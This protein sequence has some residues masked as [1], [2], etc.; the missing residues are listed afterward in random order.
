M[1]AGEIAGLIAAVAFVLL[2]GALAVPL[3]K[4]GKVLDQ[5]GR[6]V[7]GVTDR[8]VPLL[9]EVT[10]TVTSVNAELVRVDAIAAN[11]QSVS[12]NVSALTSLFAATLGGPVIRVA[13]FTYGV[14]KVAGKRRHDQAESRIK[15]ELKAAKAQQRSDR[16]MRKVS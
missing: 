3:I 4:L 1:S 10:T 8:T 2:V 14:R 6:L 16:R 15:A 7:A 13:A 11:A 5:T 12:G 9:G